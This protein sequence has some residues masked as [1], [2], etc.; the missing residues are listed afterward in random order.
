MIAVSFHELFLCT[1]NL[2][3]LNHRNTRP[4]RSP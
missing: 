3:V 4:K 1:K 2:V